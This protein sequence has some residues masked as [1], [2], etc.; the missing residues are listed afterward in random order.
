MEQFKKFS[1]LYIENNLDKIY[2]NSDF[3]EEIFN[4]VFICTT[5]EE[6]TRIFK[7][8]Y[9]D[10]II[11]N[12]D[13]G[14][15][16]IIKFV[17]LVKKNAKEMPIVGI[18]KELKTQM[19]LELVVEPE[20]DI[21]SV[22]EMLV[23]LQDKIDSFS[24]SSRAKK[25]KA[26]QAKSPKV[27][28]AISNYFTYIL[29]EL[30]AVE[31]PARKEGVLDYFLMKPFLIT[32]LNHFKSLDGNFEDDKIKEAKWRMEKAGELWRIMM[33]KTSASIETLYEEVFL[34]KQVEYL[35]LL[36]ES[37]ELTDL[38]AKKRSEL[39]IVNRHLE[40]EKEQLRFKKEREKTESIELIKKINAKSVDIVHFLASSRD[41]Q[42]QIKET[43]SA[44]YDANIE[45]FTEKFRERVGSIKTELSSVLGVMAFRFDRTI[46]QRAR[47]S[48]A[49][50]NF[51]YE[52][53]ISGFF[54]SKTFLEYYTKNI[55]R[56][57]ASNNQK[58]LVKYLEDYNKK[59]KLKVA[60][61][62]KSETDVS[63]LKNQI[64]RIDSLV[65]VSVFN[66]ISV[67]LSKHKTD[68]LHA[69]ISDYHL[70]GNK[71]VI[72]L[73]GQFNKTFPD[74]KDQV[75][76]VNLKQDTAKTDENEARKVGIRHFIDSAMSQ[77]KLTAKLIEVL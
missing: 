7:E 5:I 37:D 47:Y 4:E 49:I 8:F 55:D 18:T 12:L 71:T 70:L 35:S 74:E 17:E 9:I 11:V 54:S 22:V 64:E 43:M 57:K 33:K 32:A 42:T 68:P 14:D 77:D 53:R 15:E 50:K 6:V 61:M 75:F 10:L 38:M 62:T 60:L 76:I 67:L 51:F 40:N 44:M 2:D 66:N 31:K 19:E 20:K 30:V 45:E 41:R 48:N 27:D 13:I 26:T 21:K 56:E 34:K 39:D 52:S 23:D 36:Q 3:L 72:D 59:N 73:F 58:E 46:W 65:T 29:E 1:L 28:E 24:K 25:P 63:F 16:K 69:I